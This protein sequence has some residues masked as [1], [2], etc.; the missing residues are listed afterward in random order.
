MTVETER[1]GEHTRGRTLRPL[2]GAKVAEH[3]VV[4]EV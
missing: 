1:P 3:I 2:R 4:A